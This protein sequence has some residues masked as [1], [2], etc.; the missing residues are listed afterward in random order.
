MDETPK[1]EFARLRQL[2]LHVSDFLWAVD[3]GYFGL[4]EYTLQESAFVS[5]MREWVKPTYS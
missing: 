1:Q 3:T 5:S 2:E 4:F